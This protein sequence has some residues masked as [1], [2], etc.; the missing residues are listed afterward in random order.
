MNTQ[1]IA[2]IMTGYFPLPPVKGGAVENLLYTLIMENE[3]RK[4]F[5]FIVFSNYDN[6]AEIQAKQLQYTDIIFI[7]V[8][9]IVK[10][11]DKIVYWIATY[12]LKKSKNLSY[13]YILQR[14]WYQ[15]KVAKN[16]KKNSYNKVIVENTPISF[17]ALKWFDNL[18]KYKDRIIYHLHNEVGKTFGCDT[19]INNNVTQLIGISS[20][21]NEKFKERFPKFNGSYS[22]LKN[23]IT[24]TKK[25]KRENKTADSSLNVREEY[26]ISKN[27]FLVLFVGRLSK[28]KGV[29]EVLSAF[30]KVGIKDSHLLIVGGNYYDSDI[31]SSYEKI[32]KEEAEC[33]KDKVTFTGYIDRELV[34]LFYKAANVVVLPSMWD[35]PAGLTIIEAMNS[36][37]PVVTTISGGIPEYVGENNVLLIQRNSEI[38]NSLVSSIQYIYEH[39]EE[40]YVMAARAKKIAEEYNP[41]KYY[42]DFQKLIGE[43]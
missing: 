26:N 19:V 38:V 37:T 10:I 9:C 17:L 18:N 35:E 21:V 31:T 6:N 29:L 5:N 23:C 27:T 43:I 39:E 32:L 42:Q 40:S 33:I 11:I 22:I 13:R 7:K 3:K 36:G 16:L 41:G 20:F 24:Q 8:P 30:K 15:Y 14:L 28:E 12:I 4:K 2:F 1:N 25:S 34:D